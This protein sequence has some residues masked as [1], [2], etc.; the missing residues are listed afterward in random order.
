MSSRIK[1]INVKLGADVGDLEK[2]LKGVNKE[3]SDTGKKLKDVNK[4]LK[5]DPGNT[6]LLKQKQELLNKEI[7]A[8]KEKLEKEKAAYE[9]LAS[10]P[11]TE[12]T[13]EQQEALTREIEATTQSLDKLKDEYKDFGSVGAQQL[14]AVGDK[15]K[16]VGGKVTDVGE[17]LTQHV[18]VPIT[19]VGGAAVAAFTQVDAGADAIIQKTGATGDAAAEMQQQMENIATTIPTGFETAGNAI[20]E[21][22]TRFGVTGDALES[23]S[24]QF[25]EFA[26]LNGQDVTT[27]IDQSQA[28]MDAWGLSAEDAGAFLDTLNTVG[29]QTGIDMGTLESALTSN[30]TAFQGLGLS[31]SDAAT[32]LGTLEKSGVDTSTVITG[33]SK[34]QQ[35]AAKD[36]V[37]MS[38]ELQN[39]LTDEQSAIDIFGA[40]AGPKLYESFQN[41]TLSMEDF[42]GKGTELQ[43]N[44][45]SVSDTFN[46]TLDPI[47]Q[48]RL[49]LNQLEITGAEVGNSIMAVLQ[50]AL[51]KI[52]DA[53]AK[54]SEWWNSLSPQAQQMITTIALIVAAVGPVVAIIGKV[55]TGIG[56]LITAIGTISTAVTALSSVALGPILLVIAAVVAA[57]IGVIEVV[58]HWGEIT[59]WLSDKWS[60]FKDWISGVWDGVSEKCSAV[61]GAIG[62]FLSSTWDTISSTAS[63]VW[64][65]I[66]GTLGGIWDGISSKASSIFGSVKDTVSN[67]WDTL[68]TKTRTA[69]DNIQSSIESHGGGIK[70]VIGAAVDGYKSL[71]ETGFNAINDLTGR[72]L[73]DVL[74]KVQEKT[75]SIKDKFSDMMDNAK[76]V[77]SSGIDKIKGFFSGM[78]ISWPKIKLPHFTKKGEHKIGPLSL[79]DIGIEWYKKGYAG[80]AFDKPTVIPTLDGL[81][82]FGDGNGSEWVI[83]QDKLLAT[84]RTAVSQAMNGTQ[85]N[86]FNIYATP[87]MD[88]TDLAHKVA[89]VMNQQ[90]VRKGKVFG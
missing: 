74:S 45:G 17:S 83:G 36:G 21:V 24:Q 59:D 71:W 69:W 66:A 5:L 81:K 30:A 46:N 34:V 38:T 2:K 52:A 90:M 65:G 25:I 50:P 75:G 16:E 68:K 63:S 7:A 39:A 33:L 85:G 76:S 4:L 15:M 26:D 86:T 1:G 3:I 14:Q 43:D 48:W 57:I 49:T 51:Q 60:A 72:K 27:A 32:L 19:A 11:Q 61:F 10:Q 87:G 41:G 80:L 67:A 18:T 53:F 58:K 84:I 22:N 54:I 12:E 23:L 8:T 6:D 55:I 42:I 56:S 28:A 77:V 44:L 13:K 78:K 20:G 31:C 64:S 62:D 88:T 47:D 9:E 89:D 40:K 82:G 73:G 29:Q 79:P 35:N 37:D 70:G